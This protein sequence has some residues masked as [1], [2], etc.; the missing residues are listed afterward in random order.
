ML[1]ASMAFTTV[2]QCDVSQLKANEE[3]NESILPEVSGVPETWTNE[4]IQL[5]IERNENDYMYSF[6][7]KEG[8][9]QLK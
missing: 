9:Y 8:Y 3:I 1:S 7:D 6:S 2:L 4:M 5:T